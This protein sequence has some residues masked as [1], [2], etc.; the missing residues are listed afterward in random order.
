MKRI[1]TVT[2]IALVLGLAAPFALSTPVPAQEV[3]LDANEDG[4][5]DGDEW[6]DY[7]DEFDTWDAN[8][9]GLIEENEWNEG[10]NTAFGGA[11]GGGDDDGPLFGL[12]DTTDD[13]QIGEDEFFSEEGFG[14]L[15]DNE[16][17]MLDE[18]EFGT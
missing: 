8:G 7:G 9:D 11:P 15:D 4:M 14:E 3:D 5:I 6:G 10:V 18:D 2:A 16:D 12:L 13:N 17:G 1:P